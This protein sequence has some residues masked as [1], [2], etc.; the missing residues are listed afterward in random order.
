MAKTKAF[1]RVFII[2]LENELRSAVLDNAF[3]KSLASDGVD[4][5]SYAGVTHPSQPNY[6]AATAGLPFTVNDDPIDLPDTSIVDL[7]EAK[8]VTWKAYMEDLPE[9]NKAVKSKGQYVRK[10]NPFISFDRVRND[11]K[12][13]AKIVNAKQLAIDLKNDELPQYSWYTPNLQNDG[14]TPPANFEPNIP[15]RRVDFLAQWLKGFLP[16][17]RQNPK[18]AKGTLVVVIFDESVPHDDNQVYAVLLGDMVKPGTVESTR[19]DHYSLLRT[20]E[21]NFGLGTLNRNDLTADWF[22][23]LW[24]EQPAAFDWAM[25]SQ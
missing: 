4:L 3:M 23:F 5:S 24:G 22:R 8:N 15:L 11:P 10:H 9:N 7:L 21:E 1:D 18:F 16:P 20:V 13:L 12:R 17:L 2:V 14:H 19:F 6:L 25:H